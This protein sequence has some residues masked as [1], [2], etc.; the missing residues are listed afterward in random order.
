MVLSIQKEMLIGCMYQGRMEVGPTNNL[1]GVWRGGENSL[2]WYVKNSW[3]V[4]LQGVRY[5]ESEEIVSKVDWRHLGTRSWNS[6]VGRKKSCMVNFMRNTRN[7]TWKKTWRWL[8]KADSKIKTEALICAGQ[9]QAQRTNHVTDT[10]L[11]ARPC[12]SLLC[13]ECVESVKH[14]VCECKK[15]AQREYK[16]R[17]DN[18]AKVVG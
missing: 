6:T 5:I 8:R 1:W 2:G 9:E 12:K 17:H 10:M 7:N 14:I 15:F 3:D 11:T 18:I 4:L 13:R 16:Q